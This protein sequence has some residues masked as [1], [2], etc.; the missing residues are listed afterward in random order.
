MTPEK[1]KYRTISFPRRLADDI[2]DLVNE[3]GNW[4][5]MAAFVREA[6]IEKLRKERQAP[7]K[8][9]P[10]PILAFEPKEKVK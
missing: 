3:S 8:F 2:E 5:S 9:I 4:P 6:S 1:S 7:E 10:V